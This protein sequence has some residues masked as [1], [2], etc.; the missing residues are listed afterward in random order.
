[1][2]ANQEGY[3]SLVTELYAKLDN[4]PSG[5]AVKKGQ[6]L[7]ANEC[8]SPSGIYR[9]AEIL[10]VGYDP[11]KTTVIG[12]VRPKDSLHGF[13]ATWTPEQLDAEIKRGLWTVACIDVPLV[14]YIA[15][16]SGSSI[17]T[18]NEIAKLYGLDL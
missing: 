6:L 10:I 8:S 12:T 15:S 17:E 11:D 5:H 18:V 9:G 3:A 13:K 16:H 1:M 7:R 14:D 4:L 2:T